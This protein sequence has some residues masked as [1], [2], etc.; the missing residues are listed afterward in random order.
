MDRFFVADRFAFSKTY[1]ADA[2]AMHPSQA[3][4]LRF[5]RGHVAGVALVQFK[6]P[7]FGAC[8]Y[9]RAPGR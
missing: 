6:R 5:V 3:F 9:T 2:P 8:A 7:R 1:A 4:F